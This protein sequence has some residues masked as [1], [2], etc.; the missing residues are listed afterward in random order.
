MALSREQVVEL[1][2]RRPWLTTTVLVAL[3]WLVVGPWGDYSLN[4][5]W[6]Y[7]HLAK[8]IAATNEVKIDV[9]IA[10][11][12]VGQALLGAGWVKLFGFNHMHLRLL[13]FLL[14]TL[15]LWTLDRLL[16][17]ATRD[18]RVRLAASLLLAFNPIYYYSTASF[19]NELYGWIPPLL[20]AALYLWDRHRVDALGAERAVT[21]WVPPVAGLI[22]GLGFWTRQFGVLVFPALLGATLVS[23]AVARRWKAMVRTLPWAIL[24]LVLLG[25]A[26]WAYFEW[27]KATGNYR[28]E[29]AVR[30]TNLARIDA[31]NWVM[32]SGSV[33]VYVTLFF[34]PM[35]VLFPLSAIRRLALLG[36]GLVVLGFM[37]RARFQAQAPSDFWIGPIW[38]HKVFPWVVNIIWNAG[39]GPITLDDGFFYDAPKPS[40]PKAVWQT[41]E[42]VGVLG[43]ALWAGVG[44]AVVRRLKSAPGAGAEVALFGVLLTVGCVPAIIQS[45]QNEMV[46]RYY[47]PHLL[48]MAVA[49]PALLGHVRDEAVVWPRWRVGL[50]AA[51][52][53][54]LCLF[55]VLGAHDQF[56]WNDARWVLIDKAMKSGGTRITV[57]GGYEL[58]CWNRVEGYAPGEL[59][60]EGGCGCAYNGFCCIDDRWRVGMS[61]FQG[62]S[63]VEQ[64]QP[65]YWMAKGPPVILSRR[66]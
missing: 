11:N 21:P 61:V 34:L 19:M 55:S 48:G 23:L 53:A 59:A 51:L 49:V 3:S 24:G 12:A 18:S 14:S 6:T 60:C 42:L 22:I 37:A 13:T 58:N 63:T 56:R 47:L 17:V 7:A 10:P 31:N 30:I 36:A 38:S 5:D 62:Y 66:R 45:H 41:I 54:A 15:G 9:P 32:Q 40:W 4:D 20:G 16:S 64:I 65:N 25:G 2:L 26:I 43:A 57:Q 27:A 35:L 50:A 52:G 1:A 33:L 28:P 29:F 44:A 46:D 39:L 8:R